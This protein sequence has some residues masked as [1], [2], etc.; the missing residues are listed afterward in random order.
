MATLVKK[1]RWNENTRKPQT[2]GFVYCT[3]DTQERFLRV[4][5]IRRWANMQSTGYK[6]WAYTSEEQEDTVRKHYDWSKEWHKR[7][8]EKV[9]A[10]KHK[11]YLVNRERI[12][13]QQKEY[14]QRD[15]VK[16]R[17]RQRSRK[18]YETHKEE[19]LG[20]QRDWQ[21]RNRQLVRAHQAAY[22]KRK[23]EALGV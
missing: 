7:N 22:R 2:G 10:R 3:N 23:R 5:Q 9:K 18:Y 17:I 12:L 14:A 15:G 21:Q 8:S 16:E 6:Y 13:K 4:M 1:I 11:W 19:C 20:R